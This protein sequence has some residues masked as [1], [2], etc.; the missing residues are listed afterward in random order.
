[1][2]SIFGGPTVM[3]IF[4]SDS[5]ITVIEW[6]GRRLP[7]CFIWIL[8]LVA[9]RILRLSECYSHANGNICVMS[10][11]PSLIARI[12]STI[13]IC[14]FLGIR[15][16]YHP[17]RAAENHGIMWLTRIQSLHIPLT[18]RQLDRDVRS[19]SLNSKDEADR[20]L[21]RSVQ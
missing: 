3:L 8:S 15:W 12:R 1:M 18:E 4:A 17:C 7:S 6:S 10:G 19:I 2:R 14:D 16:K 20:R 9:R 21:R 13:R 11:D 5:V